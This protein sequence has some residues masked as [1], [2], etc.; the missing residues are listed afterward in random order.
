MVARAKLS[1]TEYPGNP[2]EEPTPQRV[3]NQSLGAVDRAPLW[4]VRIALRAAVWV[5]QIAHDRT[6]RRDL[7]SEDRSIVHPILEAPVGL[8]R[9]ER[10]VLLSVTRIDPE[11]R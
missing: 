9:N 8:P 7:L 3:L 6:L 2:L 5:E 1:K 11:Q 10:L 4:E